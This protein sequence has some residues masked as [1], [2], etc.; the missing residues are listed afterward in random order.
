MA[1]EWVSCL[2]PF[3]NCMA[4]KPWR[5]IFKQSKITLP[6]GKSTPLRRVPHLAASF[7]ASDPASRYNPP[8]MP[9]RVVHLLDPTPPADALEIIS[10]LLG[11]MGH[12]QRL[13][14]LGHRSTA[15]LAALAGIDPSQITFLHSMGW[16]DPTGW[17]SLRRLVRDYA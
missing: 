6:A 8:P 11:K 9:P 7:S 15:D 2:W 4:G 12:T 5:R 3:P 16:A 13:A 17:R 10:L 1:A 14:A